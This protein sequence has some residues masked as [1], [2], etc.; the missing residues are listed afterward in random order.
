MYSHPQNDAVSGTFENGFTYSTHTSTTAS[1]GTTS[2][3]IPFTMPDHDKVTGEF[4]AGFTYSAHTGVTGVFGES[5][6]VTQGAVAQAS[7]TLVTQFGSP[8]TPLQVTSNEPSTAFGEPTGWSHFSAQTLGSVLRWNTP[9]VAYTPVNQTGGSAGW[10]TG[11]V[12]WPQLKWQGPTINTVASVQGFRATS[13]GEASAH[14][15]V[16][17]GAIGASFGMFG[18]GRLSSAHQAIG[19]MQ[20]ELG[21]PSVAMRHRASG[22]RLSVFGAPAG[23]RTQSASGAQ[24]SA[25]WGKVSIFRPNVYVAYPT[26]PKTR[27]SRATARV[28]PVF[29]AQS[30]STTEYGAHEAFFSYRARMTPPTARFGKPVLIRTPLC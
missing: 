15:Q 16:V 8:N 29:T 2:T 24:F 12:G 11:R 25:R 9:F 6:E 13:I 7:G 27:V 28:G 3:P 18:L 23:A 10:Q 20:T 5:G 26:Q 1:F 21:S 14:T 22:V 17:A 30:M 4:K 19:A